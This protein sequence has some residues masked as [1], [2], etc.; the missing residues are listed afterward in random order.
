MSGWPSAIYTS[1]LEDLYDVL[2]VIWDEMPQT[3]INKATA[4][5]KYCDVFN[6]E[7]VLPDTEIQRYGDILWI[8][9]FVS[10]AMLGFV[11]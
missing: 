4:S 1:T 9:H 7:V 3:L 11:Q 5:S 2:S 10:F 8:C 6:T